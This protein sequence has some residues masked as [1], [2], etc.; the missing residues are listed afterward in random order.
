[1]SINS[2]YKLNN[3]VEIPK[4]GYG[5][6][7]TPDDDSGA[8]AIAKAIEIGYRH[9]DT[10]QSYRNEESVGKAIKLAGVD[11]KELFITTKIANAIDGYDNTIQSLDESLEK[12]GVDYL[13]L[14]LIHWP[15]PQRFRDHW[16]QRNR[17]VWRAMESYYQQG[18]IR[19]IGI[20]NFRTHHI[21]E[22]LKTATIKP[23]VHQI[24]LC[25]GDVDAQTVEI[26]RQHDMLLEAYSPLAQGLIFKVDEIQAIA[27]KY[28]K[29]A[30][31]VC[32]RWSLQMGFLPL[33]K[34]VT[35]ERMQANMDIFDF[36]L[37]V[38][39]LNLLTNLTGKC[40][41]SKDPDTV[42]F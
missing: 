27:D 4:L 7:Q 41:E 37:T 10:A 6:F 30:A 3:N 22:L 21:N 9:I 20:S 34:S 8:E 17:E 15:S 23:A 35:V 16:Q 31:Q 14:V 19:A 18:K 1:M 39:E 32:L 40:G 36:E 12:L 13:D 28:S 42:P 33:P 2:T 11:R 29:N 26:S 24:R 38:D 25:P 5:T